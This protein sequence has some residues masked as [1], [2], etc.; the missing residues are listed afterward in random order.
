MN[1]SNRVHVIAFLLIGGVLLYVGSA[2]WD[3]FFLPV[4]PNDPDWCKY[5]EETEVGYDRYTGPET[6]WRCV[7]FKNMLEE[8]KYYHNLN[9]RERNRYRVYGALAI[10]IAVSVL[11]FHVIPTWRGT[12][13]T[14][15]SGIAV[16]LVLGFA[17]SVL[18]PLA[19]SWALPAPVEW[20]PAS[21]VKVAKDQEREILEVLQDVARELD[22]QRR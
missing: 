18:A 14:N 15:T 8:V 20:F 17:V 7:E 5:G 19:L 1:V 2:I 10:G 9:M 11:V 16:A 6:E 22:R 12:R 21:I 13:S 3:A 4:V